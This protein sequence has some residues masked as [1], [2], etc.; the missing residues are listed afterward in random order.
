MFSEQN[1]NCGNLAGYKGLD[2][3]F[4]F[5]GLILSYKHNQYDT[6]SH[7]DSTISSKC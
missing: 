2:L 7:Q 4:F 3:F 6:T 1:V 5:K